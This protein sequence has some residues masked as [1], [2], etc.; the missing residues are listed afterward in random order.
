MLV[1][2]CPRFDEGLKNEY[3]VKDARPRTAISSWWQGHDTGS[4]DV[5]NP[6]AVE[7]FSNRLRKIQEETGMDSFKFDAGDINNVPT[8]MRL[9]PDTDSSLWPNLYSTKWTEVCAAF[10][11]LIELRVAHLNQVWCNRTQLPTL[12]EYKK[13]FSFATLI[14]FVFLQ[15]L[16][17]F[18][19]MQDKDSRWGYDNGL[20][21]MIPTLLLM[22]IQGYPFV[23]PDMIGGNA[24]GE[25]ASKELYIRW[26]QSNIFM[27]SVQFSLVP[28]KYDQEVNQPALNF[29]RNK[30]SIY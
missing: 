15:N 24:Y 18:L 25:T 2:G 11:G 3:F 4:I 6:A 10:G 21:T 5:T 13:A 22:S 28:W 20:K 17:I 29:C 14:I 26:M 16:P 27:P 19:R 7:W 23:L 8:Q 30:A 9:N 12:K 1:S